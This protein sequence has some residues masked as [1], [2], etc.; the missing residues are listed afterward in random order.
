MKKGSMT[1]EKASFWLIMFICNCYT[2]NSYRVTQNIAQTLSSRWND[3]HT[4]RSTRLIFYTLIKRILR[5]NVALTLNQKC[6]CL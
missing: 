4:T 2:L 3:A 5:Y 6:C 1:S